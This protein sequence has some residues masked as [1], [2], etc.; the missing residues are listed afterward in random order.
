M[1]QA[2]NE[3]IEVVAI[4]NG[5]KV[6]PVFFKWGNRQ[7]RVERVN[8]VHAERRGREKVHIFSVSDNANAFRLCFSTESLKWN[9]EE[10]ASL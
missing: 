6:E 1:Y 10:M 5:K 9:L 4:F 8:L 7:Y 3:P 2:V